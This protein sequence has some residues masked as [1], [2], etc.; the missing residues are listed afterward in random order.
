M[1]EADVE[2]PAEPA[3]PPGQNQGPARARPGPAGIVTVTD[4]LRVVRRRWPA[5]LAGVLL[6]RKSVV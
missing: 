1:T 3:A 2:V 5:V 4:L 6:D